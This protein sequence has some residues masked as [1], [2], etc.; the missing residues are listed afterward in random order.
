[1]LHIRPINNNYFVAK[2]KI[3]DAEKIVFVRTRLAAGTSKNRFYVHEVFTQEEIEK[4][5]NILGVTDADRP[6][7]NVSEFYRKIVANVLNVK[8]QEPRNRATA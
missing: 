1:M 4:A 3:G 7:P 6:F 5:G 2:V 8:P